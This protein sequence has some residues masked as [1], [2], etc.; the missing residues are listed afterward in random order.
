MTTFLLRRI[1][2][3]PPLLAAIS[4]FT[5]LLLGLSGRDYFAKLEE[6]PKVT[7]DYVMALRASVGKVV[8]VDPRDRAREIGTFTGADGGPQFSFDAEGNLLKDGVATDARHEQQHVKHFTAHGE[9][10]TVTQQ[11]KVYRWVG[12]V[13]GYFAWLSRAARGDL[14]ESYQYKKSVGDVIADKVWNTLK[15]SLVALVIAWG[16]AI[17]LGVWS[18]TRPN[19]VVDHACGAVAYFGLSIPTVFLALLAVLFAYYTGWFPVGGM[20]DLVAWDR[21]TTGQRLV[22]S[23]HH[24]VLPA[25][26]IGFSSMAGY[27]RQMRGQMVETM[28]AD[29][30]RT[31]RAKGVATRTVTYRHAL[32]N[33]INPLLTLLGFSIAGLLSG[34]FL[35]EVVMNWPGLAR[36]VVDAVFARDEP[37]VMASVLVAALMLVVGNFLADVLL[38]IAD[39]RIRLE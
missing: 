30:V 27:M 39:P 11:G 34:S 36:V 1:L 12:A 6:D 8:A 19:S 37:L 29:Y 35:V 5:Y 10:Y 2:A 9:A 38:A 3:L 16:L 26:V 18:G 13:R 15:L 22:D 21:M 23:A 7:Q 20:R 17:P 24:L 28:S 33:A 25:A 31:A 32:R 14:G 4:V